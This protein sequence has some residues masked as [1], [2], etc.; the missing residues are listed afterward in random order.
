MRIAEHL[1]RDPYKPASAWPPGCEVQWGDD[2]RGTFRF[3]EA[4]PAAGGF[5]RGEGESLAAAEVSCWG[6]YQRAASCPG[7]EWDRRD[8][9]DGGAYCRLC[10]F[11]GSRVLEPL[12]RC[13]QC[14]A[15]TYWSLDNQNRPWCEACAPRMPDACMTELQRDQRAWQAQRDAER[16]ANLAAGRSFPCRVCRADLDYGPTSGMAHCPDC[17]TP[18]F[19]SD[20]DARLYAE[21]FGGDPSRFI[22][23][24]ELARD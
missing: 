13:C 17:H 20:E 12:E 11:F 10:D 1:Y 22:V 23:V 2:I 19:L 7:H 5:F 14:D 15:P 24:K 3:F 9:R 18:H 4:F 21:L 8:R 16:A 6:K